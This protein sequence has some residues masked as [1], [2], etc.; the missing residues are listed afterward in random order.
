[1]LRA[2]LLYRNAN[3]FYI[4]PNVEWVPLAYYADS[5]NTLATD[6]YAV[7]GLK[8]GVDNGQ[9]SMY[10]EARNIANTAYIASTSIIDRATANSP[11][12]EPGT[13]RAVYAGVRVKW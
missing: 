3:G 7:Y 2:E 11:L 12:F 1:M 4:G 8:A 9:Y 10:V 5:A 6:A 13:G